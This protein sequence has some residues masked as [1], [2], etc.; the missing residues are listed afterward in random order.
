MSTGKETLRELQGWTVFLLMCALALAAL[1][2]DPPPL[3]IEAAFFFLGS[4]GL[5]YWAKPSRPVPAGG[6]RARRAAMVALGMASL[7]VHAL[8]LPT[9]TGTSEAALDRWLLKAGAVLVLGLVVWRARPI[10]QS[11]LH[12]ERAAT[13]LVDHVKSLTKR[14][15]RRHDVVTLERVDAASPTGS[16]VGDLALVLTGRRALLLRYE[17]TFALTLLLFLLVGPPSD[18]IDLPVWVGVLVGLFLVVAVRSDAWRSETLATGFN[19]RGAT[20]G[21]L[22]YEFWWGLSSAWGLV[23]LTRRALWG[24][25]SYDDTWMFPILIGVVLAAVVCAVGPWLVLRD[26][27][28]DV[29]AKWRQRRP[30]LSAELDALRAD[31]PATALPFERPADEKQAAKPSPKNKRRR[32]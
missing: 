24:H 14:P 3:A 9:Y 26:Q 12:P 23:L 7:S 11:F 25:W 13:S 8:T 28:S 17:L 29:L 30:D 20:L 31:W 21:R 4:A 10:V 32:G 27:A 2:M 18:F 6:L 15:R 5:G 16:Y 22:R 19:D 1:I